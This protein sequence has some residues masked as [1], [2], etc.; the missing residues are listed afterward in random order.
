MSRSRF[1]PW[2]PALLLAAT[3]AGLPAATPVI[4]TQLFQETNARIDDLFE[5]RNRVQTFKVG[6]NYKWGGALM[7]GY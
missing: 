2:L 5:H 7:A 1:H 3:A 6:L 4:G